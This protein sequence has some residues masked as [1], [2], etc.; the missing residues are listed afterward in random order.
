M[1]RTLDLTELLNYIDP[2]NLDYQEWVNV[3]MALKEEG[4]TAEDWDEWSQ[5]DGRY[6]PGECLK[7]WETF[8]GTGLPVTGATITQLAKENGWESSY[9]DDDSFLDWNDSFIATD[10][11]KGYKLVKTDWVMGKEIKEPKHWDPSKEIIDYLETV[12]SPGDIISYVSDGYLDKKADGTEK[13][14]PRNGIYTRTAGEIIEALRKNNGDVGAV[15]GDPNLACGAWI[16]F[17]PMDGEGTKNTNVVD[18]RYALVESDSM[19][20]EQ[21]NEIL[22]ELELPIV[23]LTYSGGKSLH[24]IVK[25]DAVNYPQY[26][27]RVDYLYKIVEKNGLRVDKQNKNP[28]R[29][30]RLPGF[31]RGDQKQF[32][33]AKNIGKGSWEEWQEYIEDMNDNLPDPESLADLFD[34]EIVL[35][36]ELIKGVLRQGHK[37]LIAGPSKAGKS[38]LLMQLVIAIAEGKEWLGFPCTQG[39]VLYV[40]LELDSNSAKNRIVEIYKRLGN[41]HANVSNIDIWNLRG[42]TSPMDK[43]APKLIRRA[44]KAGYIAVV[45]DPIY[46][47]LTGDENSAHEMANFTNQFDKIATEL[48]CAVIYCHHHSKGS[49]GGKNSIDRSSGSGVFARDP[50]AILDLI[51]LPVT[52]DRYMVQENQAICDTYAKAIQTY[53]PSYDSIG[54]DDYSSKKQMGHHLMAAIQAQPT[55]AIIEQER[56]KAVEAARQCSAWRLDGTLREFPR[57]K[58]VNAWFK[59]PV[60][61][62][63]DSLQDITLEDNPKEKWKKGTQKSNESRADKSKRELEEAFNILS[64][65]GSPVDVEQLADYLEIARTTV[66]TRVKKHEKFKAEDGFVSKENEK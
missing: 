15:F 23:A 47:V 41:G 31:V 18:Y 26:Q 37:M 7:K 65:D 61:V 58:T 20:I 64:E 33:I 60:H 5:S 51:E 28:S 12:F 1:Q 53:N 35:A 45:I 52:E 44:Q 21:Q 25:V 50:D 17:N 66:Y 48:G 36:P 38:F 40:N 57:F 39:K 4:Y 55:L 2:A 34:S 56:Q 22:R 46:K 42:K 13:W 14:L 19:K 3:G 8:K 27:E 9:S 11:D 62:L 6:R 49:Q 32:I 30:T 10:V 43:L 29:L 54:L 63:D 59:F 16:R 24:A